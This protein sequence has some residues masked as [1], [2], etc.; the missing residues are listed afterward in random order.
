MN[1]A[2]DIMT[3][4]AVT[5]LTG[6]AN[7]GVSDLPVPERARALLKSEQTEKDFLAL[8]E[9]SQSIVVITNSDGYKQCHSTRMALVR[10]LTTLNALDEKVREDLISTNK[11]II[12]E[13]KRLAAIIEPAK[14]RLQDIQ[15]AY[16]AKIAAEKRAKEQAEAQRKA[17][18]Q[19]L[20]DDIRNIP[21]DLTGR[22]SAEIDLHI[23]NLRVLAIDET[24]EEFKAQAE[25]ARAT[26]LVRLDKMLTATVA[27]ESEARILEQERIAQEAERQRLARERAEQEAAAA[28]ERERIA[29]EQRVAREAAAAEAARQAEELRRQREAQEA[30]A[31]KERQRIEEENRQAQLRREAEE[32]EH[33]ARLRRQREEEEAQAAERRR[34][35]E[36]EERAAAQRRAD[37]EARLAADRAEVERQQEAL[38]VQQE[39]VARPSDPVEATEAEDVKLVVEEGPTRPSDAEI[40]DAVAEAF[41]VSA[42]VAAGW[43]REMGI[44]AAGSNP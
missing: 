4:A 5:A 9:K 40:I 38:R 13:R 26:A 25:G 18:I 12:A 11:A 10:A 24:F 34:V 6:G 19:A 3:I 1:G 37:E 8:V 14:K 36:E 33:Q 32:R 44:Y 2:A 42:E 43:I 41:E 23:S 21:L 27:A 16:D 7:L 15:D 17:D 28:K 31:A 35:L 22:S 29:E 39:A 20:I 30:A